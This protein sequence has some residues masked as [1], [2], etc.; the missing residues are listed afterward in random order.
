MN[1]LNPILIVDNSEDIL[2]TLTRLFQ[3]AGLTNIMSCHDSREVINIISSNQIS[4]LILDLIMP[5]V[6]GEDILE[7]ISVNYPDIPV[8]VLTGSHDI[9]TAVRCMKTGVVFDYVTKKFDIDRLISSVNHALQFRELRQENTSLKQLIMS[10]PLQKP[11]V[12]AE[13]KT[14]DRTMLSIFRYIESV[15]PSSHPVLITGETGTGKELFARAVHDVSGRTGKM[16]TVNVAGFDDNMFSDT[17]FGHV[18]SAFTGADTIRG[19]LVE[20]AAG[21]TLFIDEIGDLS[22]QSQVKLL[23]FIQD[24]EYLPLGSDKFKKS[25]ARIIA[26]TNRDIYKLNAENKFRNDLIYRLKTHNFDIPPLRERKGDIPMLVNYFAEKESQAL[27]KNKLKIPAMLIPLLES[28]FFPGNVREL[29][30][31]IFDAVGRARTEN[32]PLNLIRPAEQKRS[33]KETDI[34]VSLEELPTIKEATNWLIDEAM[35]RSLGNQSVAARTLGITQPALSSRM[36]KK[37]EENGS[38]KNNFRTPE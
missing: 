12:F 28:Y 26:A 19:G 10:H 35:K 37:R 25:D 20:Q 6:S 23:R 27:G 24:G 18:K 34:F 21:G 4:V 13:I 38:A 7:N 3:H 31:M 30:S 33:T 1:P 15:A 32:L 16:I 5:H 8:I 36:K 29:K 14:K 2:H 22:L 11:E 17:L 9:R